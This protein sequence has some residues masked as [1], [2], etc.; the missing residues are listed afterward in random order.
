MRR[1]NWLMKLTNMQLMIS[2]RN[3]VYTPSMRA[4]AAAVKIFATAPAKAAE[5]SQTRQPE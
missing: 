1:K 4:V 3:R 2:G 5:Q